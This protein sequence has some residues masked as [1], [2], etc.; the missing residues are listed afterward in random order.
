RLDGLDAAQVWA[1][2]DVRDGQVRKQLD[3]LISLLEAL[4]AQRPLAIVTAPVAAAPGLGVADE[5]ERAHL[6]RDG[7]LSYVCSGHPASQ[8]L[9]I[10][11]APDLR[12]FR[13]RVGRGHVL[14]R[15]ELTC[16]ECAPAAHP[17]P[18]QP[19]L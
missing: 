11:V 10:Q 4:L 6:S 15:D 12:P 14:H 7:C 18:A 9:A 1:A 8:R 2:Q 5:I 3:Q 17:C 16:R 13:A 19:R